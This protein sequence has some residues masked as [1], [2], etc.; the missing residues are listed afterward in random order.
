MK[1][2]ALLA[3]IDRCPMLRTA[4]LADQLDLAVDEVDALLRSQIIKGNVIEHE[5]TAPNNRPAMAYDLA[6]HF[7]ASAAYRSPGAGAA[8]ATHAAPAQ[9]RDDATP[10]APKAAPDAQGP[11]VVQHGAAGKKVTKVDRV[12]AFIKQHQG[13]TSEQLRGVLELAPGV[14]PSSYLTSAV[15]SGRI[16]RDGDNWT[17]PCEIVSSVPKADIQPPEP[18]SAQSAGEKP[19]RDESSQP[20]KELRA[21]LRPKAS[22]RCALWSDDVLEVQKDGVTVAEL[23]KAAGE[24]LAAFLGRLAREAAPA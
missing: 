11:A 12:I 3:L 21:A 20:L 22:Y 4:Q 8:G 2:Q 17:L 18:S 7:K 14:H 5:V 24:S 13:A 9:G 1:D 23:P 16:L 19:A 10:A 15:R 6:A